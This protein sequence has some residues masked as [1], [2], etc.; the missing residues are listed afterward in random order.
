M[1]Q[2]FKTCGLE[3]VEFKRHTVPKEMLGCNTD[4]MF[5]TFIEGSYGLDRMFGTGTGDAFRTKIHNAYVEHRLHGTVIEADLVV[6]VGR[7][8]E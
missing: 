5:Q 8:I 4:F 1:D 7:K 6:C 2:A 3:V